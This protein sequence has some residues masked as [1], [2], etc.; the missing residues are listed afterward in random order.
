MELF[1]KL[2]SNFLFLMS[3]LTSM[4]TLLTLL[5]ALSACG[6]GMEPRSQSVSESQ[7][8]LAGLAS[9]LTPA[10]AGPPSTPA[11]A[12]SPSS[13][14]AGERNLDVLIRSLDEIAEL[15]RSGLW[16]TG[17]ALTES[18]IRENAGDF[19]GAVLAAYKELSWAY[20]R[21]LISKEDIEQGLLNVIRTSTNAEVISAVNGILAFQ[22]QR[23]DEA[24][25][26]F[27]TL[28]GEQEI[29]EPDAFGRWMLLVCALEKNRT[30]AQEISSRV[31]NGY[32]SIRARYAQFPEY[33]YRGARA[34]SGSIAAEYAETCINV[35]PQGPFAAE[36]RTILA[37]YMGLK[38]EDAISIR[39]RREIDF[40]ITQSINSSNPPALESLLPLI[41]LPD[42]PYTVYAVSALR[43]L[44]G[45][46]SFRDYFLGQASLSNGRLA[47]RLT[48]IGRS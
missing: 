15:E 37:L 4:S 10:S 3:M 40:I 12:S 7:P 31:N 6:G 34:F 28:F 36:C 43:N 33:W 27:H 18:S 14:S 41:A 17:M 8:R 42:N 24:A 35:S 16:T 29:N 2:K 19:T 26:S 46:Q 25:L 9:P 45:V 22:R 5:L 39:T 13:P 11:S 23:W 38:R 32:R 48:Y 20:G 1:M 21:G 44:S 47:E 30:S